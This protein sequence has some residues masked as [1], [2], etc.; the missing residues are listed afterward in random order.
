MFVVAFIHGI[1]YDIK[2]YAEICKEHGIELIEDVAQSFSGT[3]KW[4]GSPEAK[5]TMFSFGTIKTQ[6]CFGGA[7]SIVHDDKQLA[8]KMEGLQS[9]FKIQTKK[10]FQLK[11][12]KACGAKIIS[13]TKYGCK[14][15]F[16]LGDTF[17]KDREE[18]TLKLIRGF[19]SKENFLPKFNVRPGPALLSVMA[20][21]LP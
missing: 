12:A 16:I 17:S 3:R 7:V 11:I 18:L 9:S 13:G 6:T 14:S 1:R 20:Q 4:V 2:P 15:W 21:R 8:A 5:L 10:E 19:V